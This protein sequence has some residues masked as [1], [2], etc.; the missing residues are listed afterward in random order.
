MVGKGYPD[1]Y[2]LTHVHG[3]PALWLTRPH[4]IDY[5][6]GDNTLIRR[7]VESNVLL[8]EEDAITYR[9]ESDLK[10]EDALSIA[11]SLK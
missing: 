9:V 2:E 5:L 11:E 1:D 4:N 6:P 10:L 8:W 7:Y 3:Y